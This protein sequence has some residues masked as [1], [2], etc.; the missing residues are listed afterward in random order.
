MESSVLLV[1][2]ATRISSRSATT[3]GIRLLKETFWLLTEKIIGMATAAGT[4]S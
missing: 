2:P 1:V 4:W 3:T